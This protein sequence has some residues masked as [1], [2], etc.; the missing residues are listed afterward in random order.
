MQSLPSDHEVRARQPAVFFLR[1]HLFT[2]APHVRFIS[3]CLKRVAIRLDLWKIARR[4]SGEMADDLYTL[5]GYQVEATADW[6][7]AKLN[8]F[9]TMTG[10]REPRKSLSGLLWKLINWKARQ[11]TSKFAS[12]L[13]V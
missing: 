11:S 1:L 9:P 4:G 6:R 3:C 10:M 7:R 12:R 2:H 13:T 8:T 5:I